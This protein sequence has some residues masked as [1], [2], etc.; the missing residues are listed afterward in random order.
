MHAILG[1]TSV[2]PKLDCFVTYDKDLVHLL[3]GPYVEIRTRSLLCRATNI[4]EYT[5]LSMGKT[6]SNKLVYGFR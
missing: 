6:H 4:Y 3:C 1:S 2:H 5:M